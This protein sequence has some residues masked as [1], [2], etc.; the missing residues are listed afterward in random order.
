MPQKV[1]LQPQRQ[2]KGIIEMAT[3][4]PPN[5]YILD[6]QQFFAGL[7]GALIMVLKDPRKRTR[8]E[9][10]ASVLAGCG[11]SVYLTEPVIA[12]FWKEAV[13]PKYLLGFSFLFGV[14]GLRLIELICEFIEKKLKKEVENAND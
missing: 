6:A 4:P 9:Q 11:S 14:M 10:I 5:D 2:L 7:I 13:S 12:L 1:Y 8:A 3:V